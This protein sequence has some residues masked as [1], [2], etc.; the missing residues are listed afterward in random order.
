MLFRSPKCGATIYHTAEVRPGLKTIAAGTFD[1]RGWLGIDR[2]YLGAV[3]FGLSR[4]SEQRRGFSEGIA[5]E[6]LKF[7]DYESNE[8]I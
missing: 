6:R 3:E 2:Q 1:E 7:L 5:G 8:F 4:D